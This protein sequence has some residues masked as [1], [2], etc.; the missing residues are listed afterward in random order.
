MGKK[1]KA[2]RVK[3][4]KRNRKFD[5]HAE[6]ILEEY[7]SDMLKIRNAVWEKVT[8]NGFSTVEEAWEK[9][10]EIFLDVFPGEDLETIHNGLELDWI[11]N[12]NSYF[13]E[14]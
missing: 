2:H 12:K 13:D 8:E 3:V 6:S 9:S 7:V 1:A 4:A 5:A 14:L 11:K 10:P